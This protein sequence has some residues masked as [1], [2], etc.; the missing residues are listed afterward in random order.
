ME[1]METPLGQKG[2]GVSALMMQ[3]MLT[4]GRRRPSYFYP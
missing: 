2:E 1:E 4:H 3:M